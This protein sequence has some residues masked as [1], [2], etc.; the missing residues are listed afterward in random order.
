MKKSEGSLKDLWGIS[1]QTSMHNMEV[2][3][4]EEEERGVDRVFE[5]IMV[6]NPDLMKDINVNMQDSRQSPSKVNSKRSIPRHIIIILS[7]DRILKAVRRKS[8]HTRSQGSSIIDLW[9]IS[10]QKL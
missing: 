2:P 5:E 6:K 10:H 7:K 4:I 9:Q 3:K 8:S 1:K